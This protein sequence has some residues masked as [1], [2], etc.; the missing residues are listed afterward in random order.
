MIEIKSAAGGKLYTCKESAKNVK[1]VMQKSHEKSEKS[2]ISQNSH[3]SQ[4][5]F[6]IER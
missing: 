2:E 5:K 3:N 4:C 6:E 1:S